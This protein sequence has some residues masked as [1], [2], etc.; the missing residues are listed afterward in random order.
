MLADPRT[1]VQGAGDV[2]NPDLSSCLFPL[3]FW[4]LGAQYFFYFLNR[5][6][7]PYHRPLLA[8]PESH[9]RPQEKKSARCCRFE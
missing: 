6:R 9:V 2:E 3:G 8:G 1:V 5:F 7:S 4:L